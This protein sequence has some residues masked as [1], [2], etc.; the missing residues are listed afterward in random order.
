MIGSFITGVI[1]GTI[2]TYLIVKSIAT[3]NKTRCQRIARNHQHDEMIIDAIGSDISILMQY[4]G[5]KVKVNRDYY[6]LCEIDNESVAVPS[7]C[8]V[9]I[10]VEEKY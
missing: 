3:N 6:L 8:L 7:K 9:P 4:H 2:I 5:Q 10:H 1:A